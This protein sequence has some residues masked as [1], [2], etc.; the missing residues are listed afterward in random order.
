MRA[1][2][3]V[4]DILAS[5]GVTHVFGNPGTT[6]LPLLSAIEGDARFRYVLAL[7]EATAVAMADGYAQATRRPAFVNL[8]SAAGLGN[9]IGNLT[10][11]RAHATPLVVTAG[12]ADRRHLV[13]DPL[14][15]GDL[16]GLAAPTCLWAHEVRHAD[17]LG[18]VLRR[19]F[20]D[21]AGPQPGPVFVSIP[22]DIL[23]EEIDAL[24]PV[25]SDV[26]RQGVAPGLD[27]M[28]R[29]LV[30]AQGAV[31]IVAG[32]EVAV[33]GAS[34]ALERLA[35]SLGA[36]VHG[37][38][39]GGRRSFP[40]DHPLWVGP[41][42]PRADAI[43]AAL[44]AYRRVLVVGSQPFLV[45]PYAPGSPVPDSAELLHLAPDPSQLGRTHPVRLGAAGD[46]ATSLAALAAGVR[47]TAD[48]QRAI[49]A[50]SEAHARRQA[51]RDRFDEMARARAGSSPAHPMAACDAI[52]RVLPE[53]SVVVDE[54]ITASAYVRGFHRTSGA[55]T[56]WACRGGGLG[57]GM[58]AAVGVS[59]GL[60]GEPVLCV[61][62]DG[63]AMYSPQALWTAARERLPVV[64]A[65]LDNGQYRI[66]RD[67]LRARDEDATAGIDLV[68]P[69]IDFVAL[70]TAMGVT[71]TPVASASDAAGAVA[72][73]W[74]KGPHLVHI[75]VATR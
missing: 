40:V 30:E 54:A 27:E 72:A 15:S 22:V 13:A 41:L 11:A 62:G 9:G 4:L 8:H 35:E 59:L 71:A 5:E 68:E 29:L 61:V 46:L 48:L 52:L 67:N 19:A 16:V 20:L 1:A 34:A 55:H 43:R 3:I 53:E 21:A 10:N 28:A 6:E 23:D 60:D 33:A 57:W 32:D 70:A 49:A 74:G 26:N 58:P 36:N 12:N 56:Y 69:P 37:A 66:L 18:I 39:L 64:F 73:A 65:V 25:R 2:E 44:G 14:L 42:P 63:S 17:E 38:P 51:E 50:T 47:E 31:A 24:V 45:Y 7:Q 75:P